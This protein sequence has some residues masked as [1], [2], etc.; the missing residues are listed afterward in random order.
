M[1][2]TI[3]FYLWKPSIQ[4][5]SIDLTK[6][7]FNVHYRFHLSRGWEVVMLELVLFLGSFLSLGF[8]LEPTSELELPN[9]PKDLN[10]LSRANIGFIISH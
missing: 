10:L 2:C 7:G 4:L 5:Y 6:I 9:S 8:L 1:L 3:Y